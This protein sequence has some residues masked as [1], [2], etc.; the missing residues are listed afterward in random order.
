MAHILMYLFLG[1]VAGIFSGLIGVGG[2]V[3]IVPALVFLF[4]LSQHQAQGTT[5]ALL[6]PP[7]GLLAAWIYYKEGCG[8]ENSRPDM[9]GFLLGG[10]CGSQAC[11]LAVQPGVGKGVRDSL[12]S[13]FPKDDTCQMMTWRATRCGV[14]TLPACLPRSQPHMLLA[15]QATESCIAVPSS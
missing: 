6:V 11:D 15:C 1:L 8:P 5:L 4:G 3:M 12:A 7:V 9:C 13:D 10:I 2:G 14:K